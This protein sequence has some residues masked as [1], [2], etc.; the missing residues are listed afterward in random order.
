M[1]IGDEKSTEIYMDG[2]FLPERMNFWENVILNLS[3]PIHEYFINDYEDTT[4]YE[5]DTESSIAIASQIR[6]L[7]TPAYLLLLLIPAI[8]S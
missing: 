5:K 3:M 7:C 8:L 6:S 2:N 4:E 1:C